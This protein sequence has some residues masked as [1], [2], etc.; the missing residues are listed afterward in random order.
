MPFQRSHTPK[1]NKTVITITRLL[2]SNQ[3]CIASSILATWVGATAETMIGAST[4][5]CA[6]TTKKR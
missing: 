5:E 6:A 1:I 4:N 2:R 3:P